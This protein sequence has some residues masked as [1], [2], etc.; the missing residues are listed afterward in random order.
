MKQWMKKGLAA[1]L[2]LVMCLSLAACGGTEQETPEETPV[3]ESVTVRVAALKGP[4]AMGMVKLMSDS[5]DFEEDV[6]DFMDAREDFER[7][8]IQSNLYDFTL[9]ASADEVTPGLMQ[10]ELDIACVPANLASVLYNRTDGGIVTL[11]V[12]TLGVL[13]IVENGNSV[14]SMADLAGRTIAASGKG[15]TPEYA[16]RYLLTENG[17]DP[18][19]GV[20]IDWKSEHSE[21]VASLA[22][23][24]ATIAMLPQPFVTVAQTQLPDLRVALDLTEEW[25][26]LDNGSAL[27][28]GVVVAR[29]DF[30][31]EHPA[32][33]SNFLEQ[34]S[35]SVD[36]VNANTAEAAELI[37]GYDI[38]DAT[39][40]E[41]ALPYCN[42]VCVTG[43]EMMDML[44]GY[45]SVLWEQ[46]AESVGGGMPND[47]F[48]YGA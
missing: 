47:D 13:Y 39:V 35:A 29:A 26:A 7:V 36:W 12:N 42:I 5:E 3:V 27:L 24:A 33:V 19:T 9:A 25:D 11:A 28:T 23:G 6:E 2:A 22:S 20:T 21:C 15:S 38:V 1:C 45:L 4:T 48:Y 43:T 14:Q 10:G 37:G 31:K 17:I 32:A 40:A 34:Y 16:L 41:K 46:D 18:D 44:S 8:T 30:V